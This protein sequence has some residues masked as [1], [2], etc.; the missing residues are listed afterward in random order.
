MNLLVMFFFIPVALYIQSLHVF[1][2][3]KQFSLII[4]ENALKECIKES[5]PN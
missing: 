1:L 3:M 4:L 5:K 2:G